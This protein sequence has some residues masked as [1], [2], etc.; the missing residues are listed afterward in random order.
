[1]FCLTC[2]VCGSKNEAFF[3]RC[4]DVEFR[5]K[6]IDFSKCQNCGTVFVRPQPTPKQLAPYYDKEY[7][8][9]PSILLTIVQSLRPRFFG[10]LKQGKLLDVGCG[11]GHFLKAMQKNGWHC[12]G[13]EVSDSSKP[14]LEKLRQQKIDIRYG[15]LLDISFPSESFDLVTFWHVVE[16]LPNPSDEIRYVR[17]LLKKNGR[18]FVA[19]PNIDSVSF[20]LFGCNWFHLDAPRHLNH[21]SPKTLSLLLEKN[22]FSVKRVMHFSFEFNPF[23]VLQSLYNALG[24]E[25]NFLYHVIKR[26]PMQ[27]DGRYWVRLLLTVLLMLLLVPVSVIL[28]YL[29][30]LLGRGDTF[31]VLAQKI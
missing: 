31:A 20:A 18:L 23:G 25:F 11:S 16:H 12:T 22:G 29:F 8:N 1:M 4:R 10:G 7:Y 14:F 19:V 5:F 13:T 26:K 24:F 6:K 9:K 30:L 27:K 21:F 2:K 3:F 17:R 28:A 15:K